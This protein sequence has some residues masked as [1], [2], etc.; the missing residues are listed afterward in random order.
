MAAPLRWREI[1]VA[2]ALF[3]LAS[4]VLTLPLAQ[5][6]TRTLPSD[7]LDTLLTTWVISW[8]A[9]R[10]RHG[11]AGVWNAPIYFPYLRTLAYSEN[12]FGV[13]FLVAPVYWISGNPVLT[14]NV[15][16]LF[17]FTLAGTG[18]YVLVRRLTGSRVAAAVA[19]AYYAFCPYRTAQAQLAHIQMLATGW[20]P[21]ALWALH[22]YLSF[23][24][25]APGWRCS[26]RA[27]AF[28][29]CR[30]PT[31][32]T[33]WPFRSRSSSR[34]TPGVHAIASADGHSISPPPP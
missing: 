30:T 12:L 19:G 10:L 17:A 26:S 11:L 7:V 1:S 4:V 21:I 16:F 2:A 23:R 28:R 34:F 15:A 6:P 13:A 8:D 18:M 29:S 3:A 14:Y 25:G 20:L 27:V 22:E 9:D 33:S 24:C 5:H 31:S 32:P